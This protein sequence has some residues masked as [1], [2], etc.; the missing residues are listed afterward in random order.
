VKDVGLVMMMIMKMTRHVIAG[1]LK[2][3]ELK[4][5]LNDKVGPKTY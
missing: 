2:K 3:N 4:S 5:E 1:N